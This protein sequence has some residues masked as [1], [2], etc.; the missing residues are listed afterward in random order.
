MTAMGRF[1]PFAEPSAN[2]RYLRETAAHD[3]KSSF[4]IA[5]EDVAVGG[6]GQCG[7]ATLDLTFRVGT[8]LIASPAAIRH[9]SLILISECDG[10]TAP[11]P[12]RV[13]PTLQTHCIQR[14]FRRVGG[15]FALERSRNRIASTVTAREVRQLM[16]NVTCLPTRKCSRR[17]C[18]CWPQHY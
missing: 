2:D 16:R 14:R 12:H 17:F 1:S 7:A 4:R 8:E 6:S 5:R 13:S 11:S 9:W 10:I 3:A 15:L 18:C